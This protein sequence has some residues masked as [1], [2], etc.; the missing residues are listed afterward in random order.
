MVSLNMLRNIYLP[1]D[2][3]PRASKAF[4]LKS[5]SCSAHP[6]HLS[7]TL[8][9]TLPLAKLHVRLAEYDDVPLYALII[10]P[11]KGE[12]FGLPPSGRE[13]YNV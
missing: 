9:V 2:S 13:S 8:T 3:K 10:L 7:T 6:V 5:R 4:G 11:Q 1:A 12:L